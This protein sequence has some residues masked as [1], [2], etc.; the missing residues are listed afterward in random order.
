M[1]DATTRHFKPKV[2]GFYVALVAVPVLAIVAALGLDWRARHG[3]LTAPMSPAL[4]IVVLVALVAVLGLVLG[5]RYSFRDHELFVRFAV[6]FRVVI[7]YANITSVWTAAGSVDTI[8][9]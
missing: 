4:V 7:P 9:S 1:S 2:G 5:T 6:F 3:G 8:L